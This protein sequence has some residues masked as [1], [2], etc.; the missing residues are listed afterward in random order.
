MSVSSKD[1]NI[2]VWNLNNWD[3]ILDLTNI[4]YEG[5]MCSACFLSLN[6]E[7]YIAASNINKFG[8]SLPIKIFN[9]KGDITKEINNSNEPTFFND[10]YY[11]NNLFKSYII[12]GT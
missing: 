10:T 6:N 1:N 5:Y 7:I 4:N 3:C 9:I 12:T 2:K 8:S 11:D